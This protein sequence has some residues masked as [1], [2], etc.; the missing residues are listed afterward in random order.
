MKSSPPSESKQAPP[1]FFTKAD[2]VPYTDANIGP[3]VIDITKIDEGDGK[4]SVV[5]SFF[6]KPDGFN[7]RTMKFNGRE[8]TRRKLKLAMIGVAIGNTMREVV[9]ACNPELHICEFQDDLTDIRVPARFI[10]RIL[11]PASFRY[12]LDL[13][14]FSATIHSSFRR[15]MG[16]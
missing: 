16:F 4:T 12:A 3:V 15:H 1:S 10:V 8:I 2:D 7:D 5:L 9:G 11:H 13:D 6:P 14:T